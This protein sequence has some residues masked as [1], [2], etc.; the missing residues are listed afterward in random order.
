[1]VQK[2]VSIWSSYKI[3]QYKILIFETFKLYFYF[4]EIEKTC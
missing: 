3:A 4:S 2:Y 1:M